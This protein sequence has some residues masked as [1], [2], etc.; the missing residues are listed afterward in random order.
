MLLALYG[1]AWRRSLESREA[2]GL[3]S[4]SMN[5]ISGYGVHSMPAG[6]GAAAIA[7]G[8]LRAGLARA[9][10]AWISALALLACMLPFG[11]AFAQAN[12]DTPLGPDQLEQLVAPIALYPDALLSQVLMAST[13]P[14]EVVQAQRWR[15][16]QPRQ[17]SDQQLSV[18]LQNTPW[19]PSVKSLAAFPDVLQMMNDNLDWMQQLG[20]TFLAQQQD[21]MDAVQRLRARARAAGHLQSTAQ[22]TVQVVAGPSPIIEILPAQPELVYVPIYDPLV[23]YGAWPYPAYRPFY[24]HPAS[25]ISA[26]GV[27]ISFGAGL[28]VGHALWSHVDWHRHVVNINVNRYNRYN[29]A[30]IVSPNW[31]HNAQHRRGVRYGSPALNQRYGHGGP[32]FHGADR[33]G[34]PPPAGPRPRPGHGGP[35]LPAGPHGMPHAGPHAVA[36]A[37][38]RGSASRPAAPANNRGPGERG[39]A[40][41]HGPVRRVEP[42]RAPAARPASPAPRVNAPA[43]HRGAPEA[44]RA[45]PANRAPERAAPAARPSMGHAPAAHR[46]EGGHER[47]GGHGRQERKPN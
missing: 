44:R 37:G 4:M 31:V 29:H 45:P 19:D 27:F 1:A 8:A 22:Q 17:L 26:P 25:Y 13:Y 24:W 34:G 30:H 47:Q 10:A 40:A 46:P 21:V 36:P 23:V 33:P 38:A 3:R 32:A 16:G 39:G 2:T 35:G 15:V 42:S 9:A 12:A 14:L 7:P 20:D 5:M 11:Q 6:R 41:A 28:L 18:A 43:A